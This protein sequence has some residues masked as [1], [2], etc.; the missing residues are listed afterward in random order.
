MNETP[1]GPVAKIKPAEKETPVYTVPDTSTIPHDQFG[2]MIRYG[3]DLIVNTAYYLGPDG[4]VGHFL[5][6]KMNCTNCHLDAGTR[7]YGFNFF[8]SHARYP[9]YRGRENK[10]LT[11]S[12][13]INNCVERPHNGRP[14]PLDSKEI[15]AM[16]CYMKWLSSNV[17]VGQHVKG[18]E[19]LELEFPKRAAD[20]KKG[21][22]IYAENCA[23]CHGP[24]GQGQLRPDS[25]SYAY[26]PLWGPNSFQKG[27]SPSRVLKAARF[28]KAN[29]PDKK[30][31]WSK[32]FLTDEQAIDVAAFINAD[33]IHPRPHKKDQTIPD[34]PDYRMKAIDY[35]KG[36][37]V[38]TFSELQHKYGP[39]QPIIDYHKAHNLPVIF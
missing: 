12:E 14:L 31:I 19:S 7:P 3:R 34:Y 17:P 35:D 27:S 5:G 10:V 13:R 26:P 25:S 9:Q 18:D 11:L 21:A 22:A 38:D 30:A 16:V 1:T 20:P 37:Y 36:P 24:E 4:K 2:D 23:S 29:M 8:S 6:N 28:I 15:V 39:Y 33:E 32:P